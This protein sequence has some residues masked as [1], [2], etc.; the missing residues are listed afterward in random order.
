MFTLIGIL[1]SHRVLPYAVLCDLLCA[2]VILGA[3]L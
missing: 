2:S 3:F 1:V